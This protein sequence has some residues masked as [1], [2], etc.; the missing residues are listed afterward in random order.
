MVHVSKGMWEDPRVYSPAKGEREKVEVGV[1]VEDQKCVRKGGVGNGK[2]RDSWEN[3]KA[4]PMS[5]STFDPT[6]MGVG[7]TNLGR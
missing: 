2:L 3:R 6:G 7:V 5:Q 4:L 1:E